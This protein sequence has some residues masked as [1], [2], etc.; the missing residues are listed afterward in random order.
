MAES[1]IA[2]KTL[3]LLLATHVVLLLAACNEKREAFVV[4]RQTPAT[5][6]AVDSSKQTSAKEFIENFLAWYVPRTNGEHDH[7]AVFDALSDSAEWLTDE[8]AAMLRAD[9]IAVVSRAPTREWLNYDPLIISQDPCSQ[10]SVIGA[11]DSGNDIVV[12][13]MPECPYQRDY[14]AIGYTVTWQNG[15]PRIANIQERGVDLLRTLCEYERRDTQ[16]PPRSA[17]CGP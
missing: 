14:G 16:R 13:V 17:V 4:D 10:Y 15:S 5:T 9:S 1:G 3:K 7:P 12:S 8:L 2:H 6:I 11:A